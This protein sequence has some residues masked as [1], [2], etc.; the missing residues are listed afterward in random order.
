MSEPTFQDKLC[1]RDQLLQ[2]M[3]VWQEAHEHL[4]KFIDADANPTKLGIRSKGESLTVSQQI[5]M[6]V[7]SH[8]EAE[9]GKLDTE[10]ENINKVKVTAAEQN[11]TECK[12]KTAT[13]AES[14]TTPGASKGKGRGRPAKKS[15]SSAG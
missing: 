15:D 12:D 13:T 8:I 1:Q 10:V 3:A 2:T 9:I 6:L 5:I 11:E 14:T 4:A 7:R